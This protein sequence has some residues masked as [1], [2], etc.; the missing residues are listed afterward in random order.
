MKLDSEDQVWESQGHTLPLSLTMF[1]PLLVRT[2]PGL[3]P[4][5]FHLTLFLQAASCSWMMS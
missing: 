1:S 3:S 4:G 2:G 5:L